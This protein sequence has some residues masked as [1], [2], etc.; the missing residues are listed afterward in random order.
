[1]VFKPEVD[2]FASPPSS[3]E[4]VSIDDVAGPAK[5]MPAGADNPHDNGTRYHPSRDVVSASKA[6]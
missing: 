6:V 2:D 4:D 3:P 1:M 5:E